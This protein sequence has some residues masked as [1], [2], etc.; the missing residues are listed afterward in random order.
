MKCVICGKEIEKSKYLHKALCS[1]ECFCID[2]W[3]DCLD[4]KAIIINGECYHDGGEKPSNYR[5]FL[6][7]AGCHTL[8]IG[9]KISIIL[10]GCD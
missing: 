1:R 7:F 6:G 9:E 8:T 5:G 10:F 3:N 4:D 2:F